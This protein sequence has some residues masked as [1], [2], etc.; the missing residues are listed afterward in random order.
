[1]GSERLCKRSRRK[2][3]FEEKGKSWQSVSLTMSRYIGN[4]AVC[5]G[6]GALVRANSEAGNGFHR[7]KYSLGG[8]KEQRERTTQPEESRNHVWNSSLMPHS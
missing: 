6:V 3:T 1:V 8:G 7:I 4:V 5:G 2:G